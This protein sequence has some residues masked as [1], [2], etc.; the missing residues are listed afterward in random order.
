MIIS[1]ANFKGGVGKTTSAV[2]IGAG[3]ARAGLRVLLV[4][5]DPQFNLTQSLGVSQAGPTVY[6]VL[7][8]AD[9]QPVEV[10][11]GLEVLPASLELV[12]AEIELAGQFR[13]EYILEGKIK[14]LAASYD[15][16][17]IDC[18]PSLG[19]LTINAFVASDAIF[20]PVEAEFLAM[21]G[22]TIL[23][24]AL[25]N[26]DMEIDRVL[27]TNYDA[28][29]VLDRKVNEDIRKQL[30]D[31]VF[32]TVIRRNVALAEAPIEQVDIFRY[33]PDSSGAEDYQQL[34]NE[35]LATYG[36]GQRMERKIIN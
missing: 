36:K 21:Q 29:R 19:L 24:R 34:T 32:K 22:Y 8:G 3:L 4:D 7:R 6:D 17:L 1:I 23:A 33:Q 35:I 11:D 26:I 13:R 28:R 20:A 14:P 30:G 2:N 25:K 9:P 10:F 27:L 31:R 18:P 15:F 12:T 16:T 5:L